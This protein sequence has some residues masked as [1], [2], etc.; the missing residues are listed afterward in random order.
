MKNHTKVYMKFFGYDVSDFMPCE[1]CGKP[2]VDIHH[3]ESRGMGGS[4]DKDHPVNLMLLCR[5]CHEQYGSKAKYVD[6]LQVKHRSF[7][8]KNAK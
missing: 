4:N 1:L 8:L 3:I 5:E 6:E 2:G 7:M